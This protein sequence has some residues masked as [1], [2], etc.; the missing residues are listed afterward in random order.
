MRLLTAFLFAAVIA[1]G[2]TEPA[3]Q[4]PQG[5]PPVIVVPVPPLAPVDLDTPYASPRDAARHWLQTALAM[6]RE[7]RDLRA[8][9]R[10]MAQ[11][12]AQ[13]RTYAAAGFN[14]GVLC[15][16]A[17]KWEDAAGAFEGAAKLDPAA[18]GAV[19][20]P[21]AE[22]AR[23]L[24]DL[25]KSAE[26][27]RKRRYDE[28][29]LALVPLLPKLSSTEA[30]SALAEL[31]R[32]DPHR[33]EAPAL[34]A[35]LTGDGSGY[36]VSLRFLELAVKN[37][38]DSPARAGLEKAKRAAEREVRY[39]SSRLAAET[40][41]EEGKFGDASSQYEAA[42]KIMPA[43]SASA[44]DAVSASLLADDT[45]HAALLLARLR[46]GNDA[47]FSPHAT[48]MLKELAPVE[49]SAN[50]AGGDF[51]EFFQD[52]GPSQPV[53][54]ADL[55]PP[56]DRSALQIYGRPLPKLLDDPEPVVLLA[57]LAVGPAPPSNVL[58]PA[59]PQPAVAGERPWAEL[60]AL[61]VPSALD[62]GTASS[63]PPATADLASGSR[64][65][66]VVAVTSDPPGARVF[67]GE[68]TYPVCETPCN[69]QVADGTHVLRVT[70][71][72]YQ[73]ET[74][75]VAVKGTDRDLRFALRP[76]PGSVIVETG[77]PSSVTVNGVAVPQQ[78]P[79]ELSLAPGLYRIGA[80]VGSQPKDRLIM[81]K[82]AARVRLELRP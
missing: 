45:T 6:L 46:S 16:I 4:L 29:M 18:L 19:A 70:L 57:S 14:L 61:A 15:A 58:M 82:P 68:G 48:A 28:A 35:G 22:R 12:V 79:I 47:D 38:G 74:Q 62:P 34:L 21:Q 65:H 25:D 33:W 7:Q 54:I 40:A 8:G 77:M 78:S 23:A 39:A 11:A 59:L 64:T 5:T 13:D 1:A 42:W 30:F 67:A 17:E 9:I 76:I 60:A 55:I 24:A 56:V 36:E 27:R 43:R 20:K 37:A 51:K 73:D 69:L 32:I 81:V 2:Q 3:G 50:G 66:R 26:G 80:Q 31:G 72:G 52:A 44:M 63:H 53:R 49:P 10:A 71:A 41:A 75:K